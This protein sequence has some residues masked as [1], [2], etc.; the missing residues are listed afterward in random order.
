MKSSNAL[1]SVE[2]KRVKGFR[3]KIQRF[4]SKPIE[5]LVSVEFQKIQRISNIL[6]I[7]KNQC[8]CWNLWNSKDCKESK[9]H[10]RNRWDP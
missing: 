9:R 6:K 7:I 4:Q 8:K 10:L 1:E 5:V 3:K 2:S